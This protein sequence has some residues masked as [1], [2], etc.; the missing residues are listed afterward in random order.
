MVQAYRHDKIR[1]LSLL[2]RNIARGLYLGW[3]NPEEN[4]TF[5]R[6]STLPRVR[7]PYIACTNIPRNISK[8]P[9][10]EI[11]WNLFRLFV[12][13]MFEPY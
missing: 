9:A 10:S 13:R 1:K 8:I 3:L 11:E 4:I 12:R 2:K 5:P 7:E 6:G